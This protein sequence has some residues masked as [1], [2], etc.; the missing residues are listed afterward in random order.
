MGWYYTVEGLQKGPVLE[1]VLRRMIA[2][3]E[4]SGD[5]YIWNEQMGDNW[6]CISDNDEMRSELIGAAT[7]SMRSGTGHTPNRELMSMARAA[8]SGRWGIVV[9]AYLIYIAISASLS[10][11]PYVG[12]YMDWIISGPFEV[13]L[14]I[15]ILNVARSD[16][17][18]TTQVFGGLNVFASAMF[19]YVFIV[20]ISGLGYLLFIVPGLVL[21]MGYA[22]T[23]FIIADNPIIGPW[24]AMKDSWDIMR[25]NKWRLFYLHLRFAGWTALCI[26]P[27]ITGYVLV[28]V[29]DNF[30]G[31]VLL[32]PLLGLLWVIPYMETTFA[33]F[34]NEIRPAARYDARL[35]IGEDG[36]ER[37]QE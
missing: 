12:D 17:A 20:V 32:L 18:S 13:G 27:S 3:G 25:G 35:E 14:S 31:V 37:A 23:Y 10:A 36:N 2:S 5:D 4:L 8:L 1:D 6:Q 29:Y 26:I 16:Y 28:E 9:G 22:M 21:S 33:L 7:G 24:E 15:V 11:L 30:Y 34:Y 19:A